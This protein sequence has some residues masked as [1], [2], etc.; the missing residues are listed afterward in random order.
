MYENNCFLTLTYNE[1]NLT[2]K[3]HYPDAQ[4]FIKDLRSHI[5]DEELKLR[6]PLLKTRADRRQAHK[7]SPPESKKALNEK[8]R[9]S[10]YVAG[11]YGDKRKRPHWHIL[12]FNYRPIDLEPVY[13]NGRGDQVY[14]SPIIDKLWGKGFSEIGQVTLESAGYCA[15]YAS[16][17]LSHGKDGE[18]DYEPISRRSTKHAIGKQWI[19][20]YHSDVFSYGR[21][22]LPDGTPSSIPRYYEKWYKKHHPEKWEHYVTQVK[23]KIMREARERE[24]KLNLEEKKAN[25]RRSG[26]KGLQIK[27]TVAR[28]KILAQKFK[29]LTTKL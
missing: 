13:K 6:Y 19:E 16:K 28:A 25:L 1:E 2:E 3:L 8:I 22:I 23:P 7:T 26:L 17:K 18:H 14:T 20:K 21:L 9:I 10:A 4:K 27:R 5:F 24:E 12:L 29:S 15:R 11:E